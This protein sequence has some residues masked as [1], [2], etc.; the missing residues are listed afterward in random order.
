LNDELYPPLNRVDTPTFENIYYQ[1]QQ[2]N[3][4]VPT[5]ITMDTY[6]L[7]AYLTS[8]DTKKDSGGN[9]WKLMARQISRHET[10]F[11]MIPSN[12]NYSI[13]VPITPDIVVGDRLRDMY[14]LPKT[15]TFRSPLLNKTPY[16]VIEIPR[17]SYDDPRYY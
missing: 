14:T 6:H 17:T 12:V 4:N 8:T 9:N 15:I 16:E 11:Y 2:R 3:I 7:V 5:T 1:S 13:K 10:D